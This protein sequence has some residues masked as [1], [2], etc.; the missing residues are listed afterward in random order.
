M[1]EVARRDGTVVVFAVDRVEQYAKADFPTME[2]YGNTADPL[3]RL[4]PAET[5]SIR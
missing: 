4:S 3:L 1:G 5:C 2:V